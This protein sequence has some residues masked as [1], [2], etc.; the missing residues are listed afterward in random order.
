MRVEGEENTCLIG[1]HLIGIRKIRRGNERGSGGWLRQHGACGGGSGR[2]C[3]CITRFICRYKPHISCAP[4]ISYAKPPA[5]IWSMRRRQWSPSAVFW[6]FCAVLS[7]SALSTKY[8][9]TQTHRHTCVCFVCVCERERERQNCSVREAEKI[10][11]KE[12]AI[13]ETRVQIRSCERPHQHTERGRRPL[14]ERRW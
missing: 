5:A 11:H 7:A 14:R 2:S 4:H 9:G 13:A 12:K 10:T 8:K 3:C 6:K 1:I